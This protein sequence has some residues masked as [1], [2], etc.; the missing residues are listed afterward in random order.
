MIHIII[1][2]KNIFITVPDAF[3]IWRKYYIFSI[4]CNFRFT[5][6]RMRRRQF[7][8]NL[9]KNVSG[10]KKKNSESSRQER[11]GD[12]LKSLC[13]CMVGVW[14]VI[15]FPWGGRLGEEA[16]R[17]SL[18]GFICCGKGFLSFY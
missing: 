7:S 18:V 14:G 11:I 9:R 13:V 4:Q 12:V 8:K 5:L 10:K 3:Y 1:V 2:Y 17:S 16:H 6:E 15:K